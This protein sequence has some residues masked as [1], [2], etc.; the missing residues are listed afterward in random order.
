MQV[1]VLI[2]DASVEKGSLKMCPKLCNQGAIY[3]MERKRVQK[4][5]L[6]CLFG[7]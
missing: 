6:F 7:L 2:G 5:S 1:R 4:V 3:H